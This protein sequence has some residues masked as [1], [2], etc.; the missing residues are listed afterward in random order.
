MLSSGHVS[1][2]PSQ[3]GIYSTALNNHTGGSPSLAEQLVSQGLVGSLQGPLPTTRPQLNGLSNGLHHSHLINGT[4]SQHLNGGLHSGQNGVPNRNDLGALQ[5]LGLQS[6]GFGS[7]T[8]Q[9]L[10][11]QQLQPLQPHLQQ[12][13]C[14]CCFLSRCPFRQQEGWDALICL[15]W[16]ITVCALL[17]P[18]KVHAA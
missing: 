13:V 9:M 18:R 4:M 1:A 17:L 15:K 10:L 6:A 3:Q 2:A 11:H 16:G 7:L 8:A 5:G 12:P 14:L